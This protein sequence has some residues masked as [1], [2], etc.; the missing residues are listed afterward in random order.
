MQHV[1][2]WSPKPDLQVYE[3]AVTEAQQEGGISQKERSLLVRLRDSLEISASD[4]E[5]IELE[6]QTR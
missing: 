4:A 5:A 6:L 3:A 1:N 2:N